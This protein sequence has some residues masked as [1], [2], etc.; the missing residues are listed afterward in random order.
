MTWFHESHVTDGHVPPPQKKQPFLLI[1]SAPSPLLLAAHLSRKQ[2]ITAGHE[3]Q[4]KAT[5]LSHGFYIK[6]LEVL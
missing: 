1:S 4:T 3:N 5:R 2:K 6:T